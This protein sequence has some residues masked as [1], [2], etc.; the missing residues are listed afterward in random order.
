MIARGEV[1]PNFTAHRETGEQVSLVEF[2]GKPVVLYFFPAAFTA[3]CTRETRGFAKISGPLK[4]R[5]V[6]IL[7]ISVDHAEVQRRFAARCATDFPLLS[8]P[9]GAISR[10][11]GVMG[12]FGRSRRVT[13]L[14]DARGIVLEVIEGMLPDPHVRETVLQFLEVPVR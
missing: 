10:L 14:I 12:W 9:H 3:G 1:A 6:E 2:R 8:D 4:A 7:G 5:G 13:F 11:Y